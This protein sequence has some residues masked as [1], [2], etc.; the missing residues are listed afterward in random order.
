MPSVAGQ[1]ERASVPGSELAESGQGTSCLWL[2]A[3]QNF[4]HHGD[5]LTE[6]LLPW[7]GNLGERCEW[8]SRVREPGAGQGDLAGAR[9]GAPEVVKGGE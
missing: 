6:P 1:G 2:T 9:A 3:V 8:G 7:V 4:G 5:I